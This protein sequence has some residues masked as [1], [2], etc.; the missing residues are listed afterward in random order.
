MKTYDLIKVSSE[1]NWS[2][3]PYVDIDIPYLD[4]PDDIHA[5]AQIAY[6]EEA[7][8]LHLSTV[9]KNIRAEETGPIGTPC[10]DSCLEF[11]FSPMENDI[12]YFN[13]EFNLNGC[14]YLGIGSN[15]QNLVRLVPEDTV[16]DIFA[17]KISKTSDG[18]EIFYTVPY[19][20]IKRFFPDFKVYEGKEMRANFYKCADFSETP[21]Y[22]S[23]SSVE[24]EGE[25]FTFHKPH[26]FGTMIFR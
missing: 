23:W 5:K 13:I 10:S 24:V 2:G 22:L 4:T 19:S 3:I 14:V 9:E 8:Y 6:G 25:P 21:H 12:R 16:E 17:P 11:F 18:W 7:F 20:F 15:V 26:C 1:P